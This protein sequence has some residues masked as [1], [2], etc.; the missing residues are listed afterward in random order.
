M[1][2]KNGNPPNY[3][4]WR[5]MLHRCYDK[6]AK[7]YKDYGG[8]G[9]TVCDVW[10]TNF[11]QFSKDMGPR[12]EGYTLERKKNDEGYSKKNCKW[13]SRK[14]QQ[15]NQRVTRRVTIEGIEY[16]AANLADIAGVKT[17]TII[18][19]AK[20]GLPYHLVTKNGRLVEYQETCRRGHL[21]TPENTKILTSSGKRTCRT[22]LR[23]TAQRLYYGLRTRG[24]KL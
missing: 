22:C 8:R 2:F 10:R 18:E 6:N 4:I 14:E 9:I 19:R 16:V 23:F 3:S 5:G 11:K 24:E 13:A 12:P 7:Q 1:P 21:Y 17:D 20:Q 15:R